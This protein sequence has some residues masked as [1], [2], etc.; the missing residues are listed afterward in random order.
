MT[1]LFALEDALFWRAATYAV[2]AACLFVIVGGGFALAYHLIKG[3]AD[4]RRRDELGR[5]FKRQR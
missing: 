5:V 2:L 4:D 1:V 3:D